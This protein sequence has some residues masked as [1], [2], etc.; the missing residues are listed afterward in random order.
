MRWVNGGKMAV[1]PGRPDAQGIGIGIFEK[2]IE[3]RT[4]I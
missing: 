1:G 4:Y 2:K 3:C